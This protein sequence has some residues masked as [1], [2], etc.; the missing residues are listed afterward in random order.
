MRAEDVSR[1]TGEAQRRLHRDRLQRR[2]PTGPLPASGKTGAEIA[3]GAMQKDRNYGDGV[4]DDA[5]NKTLTKGES[6]PMMAGRADGSPAN[7]DRSAFSPVFARNLLKFPISAK[8][9][10]GKSLEIQIF[11]GVAP[12]AK[13]TI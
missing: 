7:S 13:T 9:M 11:A 12:G 2:A 5:P 8:Q 6:A 4:V 1:A 10:F 3:G